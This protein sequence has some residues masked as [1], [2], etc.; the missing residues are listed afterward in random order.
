MPGRSAQW[1]HH[2]SPATR[3]PEDLQHPSSQMLQGEGD[4]AVIKVE[5][6]FLVIIKQSLGWKA[7]GENSRAVS[8]S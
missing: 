7:A 8:Q 5:S 6:A 4:F 3:S 1:Q 2:Q